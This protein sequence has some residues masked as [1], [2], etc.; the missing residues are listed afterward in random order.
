MGSLFIFFPQAFFIWIWLLGSKSIFIL[1]TW[2]LSQDSM[3]WCFWLSPSWLSLP[4]AWIPQDPC[5][6]TWTS[7]GDCLRMMQTLWM[8]C[9]PSQSPLAWVLGFGGP[10]VTLTSIPMGATLSQAVDPIMS[11]HLWHM[12]VS[13]YLICLVFGYLHPSSKLSRAV[14]AAG[15]VYAVIHISSHSAESYYCLL[16]FICWL[17][18]P[19]H[20]YWFTFFCYETGSHYVV[21]TGL[22]LDMKTRLGL[23]LWSSASHC[24]LSTGIKYMCHQAQPSFLVLQVRHMWRLSNSKVGS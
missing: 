19:S 18:F 16:T 12:E 9:T 3:P 17:M 20:R 1:Q 21:L 14:S 11:W 15:T 10:W 4:Q 6:K 5:L 23:N 8:S 2:T 24:L 7:T 13:L 22:G